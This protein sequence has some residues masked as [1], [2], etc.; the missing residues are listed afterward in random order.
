MNPRYSR[1][2]LIAGVSGLTL[3]LGC[4][5]LV[6]F[7]AAKARGHQPVPA[8]WVAYALIGGMLVGTVLFMVALCDFAK[9]KG[10]SGFLGLLGSFSCAGLVIIVFLPDRTKK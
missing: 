2:S 1:T 9:A 3:Q 7:F 4:Y 5:A 6:D 10:Y 8:E